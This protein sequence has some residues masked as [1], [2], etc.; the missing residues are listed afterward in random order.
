MADF[1]VA[2]GSKAVRLMPPATAKCFLNC[3]KLRIKTIAA[4]FPTAARGRR[5]V[6]IGGRLSQRPHG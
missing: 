3:Q 6:H 1:E 2:N 5:P 4:F